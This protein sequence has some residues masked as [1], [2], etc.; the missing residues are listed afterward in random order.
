MIG[1]LIV[2][3]VFGVPLSAIWTEHLR[4]VRKMELETRGRMNDGVL[5]EIAAL[6]QELQ[7]LRDTTTQ[8]DLSFDTAL[9]NLERRMQT[10]EQRTVR[11][12]QETE[13]PQYQRNV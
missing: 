12:L 6:R 4:Q 2:L 7:S 13:S 3:I 1:V 9:Q 8:Y 5:A 11:P 10:L